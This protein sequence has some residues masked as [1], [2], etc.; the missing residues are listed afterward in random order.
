MARC[1]RRKKSMTVPPRTS[2]ISSRS[3]TSMLRRLG[4]ARNPL[5]G[6]KF[7]FCEMDGY[8][9]AICPWGNRIRCFEPHERFGRITL[10]IPYVEFDVPPKSA[11]GIAGFYKQRMG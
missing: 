7:D 3:S 2:A 5:E 4:R 9:E 6:T 8:V 1:A 10:R 11:G